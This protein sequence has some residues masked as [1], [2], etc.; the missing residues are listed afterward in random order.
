[1]VIASGSTDVP[2]TF[3]LRS[4]RIQALDVLITKDSKVVA[5]MA[6]GWSHATLIIEDILWFDATL[7]GVGF[8][9][10]PIVD[11]HDGEVLIDTGTSVGAAVLRHPITNDLS[12]Q[13]F[14]V[15]KGLANDQCVQLT[16]LNYAAMRG[17]VDAAARGSQGPLARRMLQYLETTSIPEAVDWTL[18]ATRVVN[19]GDVSGVLLREALAD[20]PVPTPGL[21]CSQLVVALYE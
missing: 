7:E 13:R 16:G 21:F 5:R 18:W 4:G 8:R 3:A 1:V 10:R 6:S 20:G 2:Y 12:A 19:G 9:A 11:G 14:N 15:L 17:L